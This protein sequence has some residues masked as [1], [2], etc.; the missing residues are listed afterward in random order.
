[1]IRPVAYEVSAVVVCEL[2]LAAA[3]GHYHAREA[4]C[5]PNLLVEGTGQIGLTEPDIVVR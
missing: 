5:T 4:A 2:Q 1:M 3:G